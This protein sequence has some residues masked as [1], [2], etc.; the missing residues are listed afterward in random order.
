M[1]ASEA[2][3]LDSATGRIR[4]LVVGKEPLLRGWLRRSLASDGR[5]EVVGEADAAPETA[6][7]AGLVRPDIVV[8]DGESARVAGPDAMAE[9]GRAV[10]GARVVVLK[11]ASRGSDPAADLARVV[12]GRT[13]VRDVSTHPSP[14][15]PAAPVLATA[16]SEPRSL[17]SREEGLARLVAFAAGELGVPWAA[18]DLLERGGWPTG[19][20]IWAATGPPLAS[21][22]VPPVLAGQVV[23]LGEPVVIEN[24]AGCSTDSYRSALLKLGA[25]AYAGVPIVASGRIAGCLSVLD[26]KP[27]R[28]AQRELAFLG[29]LASAVAAELDLAVGAEPA[30]SAPAP[31]RSLEA[32]RLQAL[33]RMAAGV[34]HDFNNVLAAI[35]SCAELL[36]GDRGSDGSA[37][38]YAAEIRGAAERGRSLVKLLLEPGGPGAR[39]PGLLDLD[40]VVD[41]VMAMLRHVIG[42]EIRIVVRPR[43]GPAPVRAV[44]GRLEQIILNLVVNARDAMPDGGTLVVATSE[45][46]VDELFASRHS[47][48]SPG[49]HVMLTVSDTGSGMDAE[50]LARAFEPFYTTKDGGSGLGLANVYAATAESHGAVSLY[51][52]PGSGTTFRVF[53][54]RAAGVLAAGA[55]AS[56]VP[57]PRASGETVLLVEDDAALRALIARMLAHE[58]YRVLEAGDAKEALVLCDRHPELRLLFT[59]IGLPEVGGR[60]LAEQVRRRRP[61]LPV[62]FASGHA[63]GIVVAERSL[64]PA[65]RFLEKPFQRGDLARAVRELLDCSA[66]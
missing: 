25:G 38:E 18:L 27:R 8:I 52:A 28:F 66:R 16:R 19:R 15:S 17:T 34:A 45:L 4:I 35:S 26:R 47:A 5:F 42:P 14:E 46:D 56:P 2:T 33:G 3:R 61:G 36:A 64:P 59:D 50:T 30:H 48:L 57:P 32:Q 63:E 22:V 62:L 21:A 44:R 24:A 58:G 9:L 53:L 41:G 49:P 43:R 11:S 12:G 20:T 39:P 31:E 7:L 6:R 65:S 51:S 13:E 60:A 29:G 23:A 55:A 37:R 1:R 54:P 40:D 10:P